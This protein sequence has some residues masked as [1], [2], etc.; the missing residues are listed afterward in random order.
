MKKI[1]KQ[2]QW[3]ELATLFHGIAG[4]VAFLGIAL[5]AKLILPGV[6]I[7]LF[8]WFLKG[9]QKHKLRQML[10]G[11]QS[12]NEMFEETQEE[13]ES[14]EPVEPVEPCP[15][16]QWPTGSNGPLVCEKCGH[17]VSSHQRMKWN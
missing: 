1:W 3:F 15:P 12:F 9:Y 10:M 6:V 7:F 17:V 5:N 11:Y 4:T 16:H 8:T 14:A 2:V 13:V